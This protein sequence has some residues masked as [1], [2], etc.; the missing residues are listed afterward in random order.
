MKTLTIALALTILALLPSTDA[1]ENYK[2]IV[3]PGASID[4]LSAQDIKDIFL[5]TKRSLQPVLLK[6]GP[7]HETFARTLLGKSEESLQNYYRSLVFSGAG[8]VPK[9][10]SSESDVVSYVAKTKGAIGYVSASATTAGVK[11]I[12]VK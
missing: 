8:G 6:G 12:E 10:F 11:V 5:E 9:A 3:N 2:L 4:S 7:V 1:A